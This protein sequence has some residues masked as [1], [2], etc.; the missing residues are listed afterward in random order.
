MNTCQ[1]CKYWGAG[2]PVNVDTPN[3]CGL[4]EL[5]Y[6]NSKDAAFIDADAS[7][8]SGL[9]ANLMTTSTFGCILHSTK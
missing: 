6:P 1:N 2:F 9:Y 4:I 3:K 8:D 5:D 7:D